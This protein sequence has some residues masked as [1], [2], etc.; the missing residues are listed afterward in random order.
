MADSIKLNI[1]CLDCGGERFEFDPD[2]ADDSPCVC[3]GC[4]KAFAL[5]EAKRAL[6][7]KGEQI[8]DGLVREFALQWGKKG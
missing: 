6:I 1:K 4:G 2:G 3:L 7:D 5:G 8:R